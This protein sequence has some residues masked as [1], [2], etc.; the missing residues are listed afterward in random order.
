MNQSPRTKGSDWGRKWLDL[1]VCICIVALALSMT[2]AEPLLIWWLLLL[3]GVL[4][5]GVF[6][7]SVGRAKRE[8]AA[9]RISTGTTGQ[10][11]CAECNALFDVQDLVAH[12]DLHV[13]AHCKPI[14]LQ[15]L[16][17][18]A[19]IGSSQTDEPRR[20]KLTLRGFWLV[21]LIGV[22][23]GLLLAWLLPTL[24]PHHFKRSTP[25]TA[26]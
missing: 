10:A 24:P 4:L 5:I 17:E 23:F 13:C 1:F 11:A 8:Q 9:A 25:P 3:I 20:F 6:E 22:L 21:V 19:K 18:G 12:N 14:F 7:R 2:L 26:R 16:A 15:K